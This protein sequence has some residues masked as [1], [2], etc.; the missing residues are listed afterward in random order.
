MTRKKSLGAVVA[1]ALA[2]VLGFAASAMAR[3][4]N[5][6]FTVSNENVEFNGSV[7]WY[8]NQ[9]EHGGMRVSGNLKDIKK[10]GDWVYVSAKVSGYGYNRLLENHGGKGTSAY[11]NPTVV[12]DPA[13]TY[14]DN[15]SVKACNNDAFSDTCSDEYMRR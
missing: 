7:Y 12:Y 14:V 8:A 5:G 2:L 1:L 15:G 11:L 3:T 6:S 10:N 9:V 4:G 13:A